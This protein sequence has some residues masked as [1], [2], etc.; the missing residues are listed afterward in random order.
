DAT[1]QTSG[2][3]YLELSTQSI[4]RLRVDLIDILKR[5]NIRVFFVDLNAYGCLI[6]RRL[7]ER[8][9]QPNSKDSCD[10]SQNRPPTDY[11]HPPVIHQMHGVFFTSVIARGRCYRWWVR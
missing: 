11:N 4:V 8:I 7:L 5:K 9:Y 3:Q 2:L 6:Y 10:N 1:R